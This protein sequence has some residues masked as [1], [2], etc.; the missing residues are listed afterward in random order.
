MDGI[1][2]THGDADH[3]PGLTEI[4]RL[5]EQRGAYKRLFI[6]PERVY[7]NG[8]VK[9]PTKDADRKNVPDLKLLGATK[10]LGRT[11]R[12]HGAR[13]NLLAHPREQMNEPFKRW[14]AALDAYEK[15]Y[16]ASHA[17][18]RF[19]RLAQGDDDAFD[20]LR[21]GEPLADRM[22]VEVSGP[23]TRR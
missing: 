4:H 15:R 11:D 8:L 22:K 20:F 16:A 17:P 13:E 3:F 5:G 23:I 9:R 14:R 19:R 1:V 21:E 12:D 2:V 18:I 7:H 6:R 10:K